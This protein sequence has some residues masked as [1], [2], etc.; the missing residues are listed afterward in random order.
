M[1]ASFY[2]AYKATTGQSFSYNGGYPGIWNDGNN[3]VF[4]MMEITKCSKGSLLTLV[5]NS[6]KFYI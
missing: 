6:A 1:P 2:G 5:K 4:G 3:K